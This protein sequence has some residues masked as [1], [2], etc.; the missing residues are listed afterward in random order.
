MKKS[1]NV[2]VFGNRDFEEGLQIIKDAGF[3]AVELNARDIINVDGSE[4]GI[5]KVKD[6]VLSKGL[7]IASLLGGWYSLFSDSSEKRKEEENTLIRD[8]NICKILGTDALL[9]VPG[10]IRPS[11]EG[12]QPISYDKAYERSVESLKRVAPI[13]EEN[14][15]FICVENVWNNFLIT[16]IEMKN[17]IEEINSEFVGVYFDVGNIL[18]YGFPEM[19]IRILGKLIKRIHLK[20]FKTAVGNNTGFCGLLQGDVNWP[21]VME[22]LRETGYNS[23]LTAEFGPYRYHP[24]TVIYHLSL[25]ID[26]ILG[27]K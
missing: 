16:P 3:E 18:K 7:E 1:V 11:P 8:I 24:E 6:Q 15:V 26:K 9:V 27:R 23:Y 13:A 22:A 2:Q 12:D 17:L 10:A 14:K 19:W 5:K 21:E 25:S 4:E 20:D